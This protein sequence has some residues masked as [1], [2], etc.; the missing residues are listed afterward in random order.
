MEPDRDLS[1]QRI[2]MQKPDQYEKGP[3]ALESTLYDRHA[4]ALYRY[5]FRRVS[6]PQDAED[7]L[8]EV[9]LIAFRYENLVDLPLR[10]QIA[11]LQSVARRRI[12]DRYRRISRVEL[13]PLEQTLEALDDEMT[14]EEQALHKET[15]ERLY[16][17]L[18]Q[19]PSVQQQIVHLRYG[20]GLR[21]AEIATM[22][23]KSEGTVRKMLVRILRQLRAIYNRQE[24]E[25]D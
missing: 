7:M 19:L 5:I 14:P 1:V 18:A 8:L 9:F 10:R 6:Q 2:V 22:L 21:F 17:A 15:Y 20:N 25:L 13:L 24:G 12:I 3:D 16:A 23:N 11:W 4:P